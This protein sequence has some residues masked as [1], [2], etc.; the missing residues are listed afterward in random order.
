MMKA[1]FSKM[2]Y[3]AHNSYYSRT[4]D[5]YEDYEVRTKTLRKRRLET[6]QAQDKIFIRAIE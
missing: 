3:K 4:K 1:L 6:G 2:I 5:A